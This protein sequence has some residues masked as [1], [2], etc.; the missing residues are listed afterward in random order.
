MSRPI[1]RDLFGI[2]LRSLALFRVC[3]GLILVCDAAC[4]WIN[5]TAHYS[6]DGV[7]PRGVYL[8]KFADSWWLS[9]HLICGLPG[10]Q[11]LLF[12]IALVIG[13]LVAAGYRSRL[14]T[15]LAWILL[16]SAQNRNPVVLQGGDVVLR[17]ITF[18]AMFLPLGRVYSVDAAMQNEEPASKQVLSVASA[19]LLLQVGIFYLFAAALKSG[20]EWLN[21]IAAHQALMVDQFTTRIGYLMLKFPDLLLYASYFVL[22]TEWAA[23]FLLFSPIFRPTLRMLG[24]ILL[25]GMQL[26]FM[27]NMELGLFPWISILA[28]LPFVPSAIWDRLAPHLPRGQNL[29]IFWDQDCG[30]C[31]KMTRI[32]R[33]V[34]QITQASIQPAQSDPHAHSLM[35][36]HNSWVVMNGSTTHFGFDGLITVLRSS[37]ARWLAPIA[38]LPPIRFLGEAA[39]RYVANHRSQVS[40]FTRYL[41]EDRPITM[42]NHWL[43]SSI[44]AFLFSG[45]LLWNLANFDPKPIASVP[46]WMAKALVLVRL[47]QKWGMFA[48]K[49]LVEDGWYVFPGVLKDGTPADPYWQTMGAPTWEKP[50]MVSHNF[51]DQRWRKY[52]MNLWLKGF[53][54]HRLHYGRYLCRRWNNRD[55]PDDKRLSTFEMYFMMERTV[56][57]KEAAPEKILLWSHNCLAKRPE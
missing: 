9:L 41:H 39:Y 15:I 7:L 10:F 55:I 44:L 51:A 42:R 49:P 3:L 36:A 21:G 25:A 46:G 48:P 38:S 40:I 37:A 53:K 57:L 14:M 28:T 6:D 56:G 43:T 17:V 12:A 2:D 47:D 13:L 24:V 1:L 33:E 27:L 20:T 29:K 5:A 52:M 23:F 50:D 8:E 16:I 30:F 34:L 32:I 31:R 54:E 26:S 19:C 35:L 45:V 11:V 22:A 4:S 18:W